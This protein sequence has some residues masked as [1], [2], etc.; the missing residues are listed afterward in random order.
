ML[1]IKRKG[2]SRLKWG[3]AGLGSFSEN[4]VIPA[5]RMVQR[6]DVAAV[7]SGNAA[8]AKVVAERF[9]I[10]VAYSSFEEFL[11]SDIQAVYI[12]SA[13][14][15]HHWQVIQAARAGKH[16]LCDKPLA[17]NHQQAVEMRDVCIASGVHCAVNFVYRFHPLVLKAKE[18]VD[19]GMIG[20][21]I[22]V[23]ADFQVQFHPTDNYRYKK[24]A[25]GGAL[26]DLGPHVLDVCRYLGGEV[27]SIYGQTGKMVYQTEV[28]DFAAGTLKFANGGTGY[29]SVAFCVPRGF[30]RIEVIG[31]KGSVSVENIVARRLMAG[32]LTILLEGE[33]KK[34]FSKR[35]NKLLKLFRSVNSSFLKNEAPSVTI[36]DGVVNMKLIEMVE[37]NES[38]S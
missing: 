22:S 34:V 19:Q 4:S 16:I 20:K 37:N 29:F 1:L 25:G 38:E 8:R 2:I 21:I 32:K 14:N 33:Y 27:T 13:N 31:S 3:I 36:E 15:D 7:Y 11:A 6:A 26:R 5:F 12:G 28:D 18:L 10:P 35:A 9:S 24:D 17:L 30:N 23:R